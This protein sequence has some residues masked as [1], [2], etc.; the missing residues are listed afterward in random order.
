MHQALYFTDMKRIKTIL[1]LAAL[2]L[3][4]TAHAQAPLNRKGIENP[5]KW[6]AAAFAKGAV[7]PFSF[8]LDG[9]PSASFIKGWEYSKSKQPAPQPCSVCWQFSWRDRRSGLKVIATVTGYTDFGAVEWVLRFENT[10]SGATGQI[11]NVKTADFTLKD[12]GATGYMMRRCKGSDAEVDDF[13]IIE[14]PLGEGQNI[15]LEAIR[16]RSSDYVSLPF[17]NITAQGAGCGAVVSVGWTGEW[18]AAFK[19]EK[20]QCRVDIGLKNADFYL[21]KGEGVRAPMV[22]VLFWQGSHPM[23]GHNLF[24]RFV[25]AHHSRKVDGKPWAPLLGGLDW[26]DPAPCNEYTC[27]TDELARAIVR[28]YKQFDIVPDVFW[29]DAGWYETSDGAHFKGDFSWPETG[30]WVA[31]R[32]RFPDGFVNMSNLMHSYG[33]E[34]MVWFEPERVPPGSK[35]VTEHPEYMLT[36]DESEYLFNL[37]DP[38]AVEYL[39]KYI[40]DFIEANGIDHYRQDFNTGRLAEFWAANDEKGRRGITEMKYIEGLY[41]YWDY[42]ETR[43]PRLQIDNCASG[44][45]RLDLETTSRATPLW[46]TDY[47]YGEPLG[48]QCQTYGLNMFLPLSCTGI[49]KTD[50]YNSRSSYSSALVLNFGMLSAGEDAAAMK[51]VVEE[52][53]AL[54]PY[55]QKD[56]YPL[57]G[58][59][60]ITGS[61]I[62]VA[63][64]LHDPATGNGYVVAF[65]RGDCPKTSYAVD[66]Q[67]LSP[68]G[69]YTVTDCNTGE[70]RELYGGDMMNGFVLKLDTAP[71]SILIKYEKQ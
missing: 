68:N 49:Y 67:A 3:T 29:L 35:F 30:T 69:T 36:I 11:A 7:P 62:W 42:L 15:S 53:R 46:R 34:F 58:F 48:Y 65:R 18:K 27:L 45:R 14:E 21:K 66:M 1:A 28:R 25:L 4:L 40:G 26:G 63:Y 61:D 19:G 39:C 47:H 20:G 70:S 41:R 51:R 33:A 22:S 56:Y 16:G 59:G 12:K 38:A 71:E 60:N 24:R 6:I 37:S 44:G 8:T 54:Q 5:E 50:F 32:E 57:S 10:G 2:T 64:Q 13:S 17:F 55:Y 31:D 23:A 9:V 43:F 52:Y